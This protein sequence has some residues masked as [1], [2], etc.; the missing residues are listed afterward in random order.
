MRIADLLHVIPPSLHEV[1]GSVFNSGK[2]AYASPSPLYILGLNPGG[3]PATHSHETVWQHSQD[4]VK[5]GVEWSAFRDNSWDGRAPG[6]APLQRSVLHM[7]RKLGLNPALVPTSNLVF[8]RSRNSEEVKAELPQLVPECWPL[9][10][11][12]ISGLGIKVVLCFERGT[13]SPWLRRLLDA[14]ELVDEIVENNNRRYRSQ[15]HINDRGLAVVTVLHGSR[16]PW[17]VPESDPTELV[18]RALSRAGA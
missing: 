8:K 13:T 6:T 5:R 18:A 2:E 15:T 11:R 9:H 7:M 3:D 4:V 10:E 14:H 17:Y 12:V 1:S 16:F